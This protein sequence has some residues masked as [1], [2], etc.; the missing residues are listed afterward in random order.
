MHSYL[1]YYSVPFSYLN[2]AHV[3]LLFFNSL[4]IVLHLHRTDLSFTIFREGIIVLL[5]RHCRVSQL[6]R[7]EKIEKIYYRG[8][9]EDAGVEEVFSSTWA[10][11]STPAAGVDLYYTSTV[12]S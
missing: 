11:S 12:L 1:N 3:N 8:V 6:R 5:D 9:C 10:S 7:V 2:K 4:C